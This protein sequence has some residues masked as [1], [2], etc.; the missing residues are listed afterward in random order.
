MFLQRL[1]I[2]ALL[3][4]GWMV[5]PIAHAQIGTGGTTGMTTTTGGTMRITLLSIGD[6]AANI[7]Q[8]WVGIDD[9]KNDVDITFRVDGA[10]RTGK[11]IDIYTGEM[12]NSTQRN[13][14]ANVMCSFVSNEKGMVTQNLQI[15]ISASK[16]IK[17]C[18]T[19]QES[20]PKIW[21]LAV[22]ESMST[23][24]VGNLWGVYTA[25]GVDTRAPDSPTNVMGG[26][27]EHLIPV[28]WDST[29]TNLKG[30]KVYIDPNPL[31]PGT[32]VG[33]SGSGAE[34]DAGAIVATPTTTTTD[35]GTILPDGGTTTTAPGTTNPEC[36]SR[37]LVS[38]ANAAD[39]PSSI[40]EKSINKPTATELDITPGDI[41]S[42]TALMKNAAIAVV[43]VDLAQN[44]S[45]LSVVACL[46]VAPTTS[47]W[48]QYRMQGGTAD[49]GCPCT[50]MGPAKVE[51]AWPV[52]LA[53][54]ML[55][56]SSHRRRRS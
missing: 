29:E 55:G 53:V 14:T 22:S 13:N 37:F 52:G 39:L 31:P 25:L 44:E 15:H 32:Q 45:P 40:H 26:E 8:N 18:N 56:L 46:H 34:E 54:I 16:L 17:N 51:N 20:M 49:T 41:S 12:C 9:C 6:R 5:A 43:A 1:C 23:E 27:G 24:E 4:A 19:P 3:A 11:S 47:F 30:F 38:G 10:P 21:F 28:T 50:A 48:D 33:A 42:S 35:A 36:P 2:T 7:G